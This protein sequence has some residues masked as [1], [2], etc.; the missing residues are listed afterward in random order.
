M[1]V[2]GGRGWVGGLECQRRMG[3]RQAHSGVAAAGS[4]RRAGGRGDCQLRL[5]AL[6]HCPQ[7][8]RSQRIGARSPTGIHKVGAG[9]ALVG[10]HH[11]RGGA[12]HRHN[13]LQERSGKVGA[14]FR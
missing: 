9:A 11:Q 10:R 14:S 5:Q 2:G 12:R 1:E 6:E 3:E 8:W 7:L 4:H 13:H